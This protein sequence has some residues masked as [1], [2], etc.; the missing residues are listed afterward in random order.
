MQN[1]F[2]LVF[3]NI[4]GFESRG[5]EQD[6]QRIEGFKKPHSVDSSQASKG[7]KD[8]VIKRKKPHTKFIMSLGVD[9]WIQEA[10]MMTGKNLVSRMSD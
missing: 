3:Q 10:T 1:L 2:V 9:V 7:E 5:G 8:R 4:G 6:V